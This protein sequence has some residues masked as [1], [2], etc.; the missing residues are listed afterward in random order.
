MQLLLREAEEREVS[1]LRVLRQEDRA[2]QSGGALPLH[3]PF[4]AYF[5]HLRAYFEQQPRLTAALRGVLR[6][7]R[8]GFEDAC[9]LYSKGLVIEDTPGRYR[10]RCTLYERYLRALWQLPAPP[11]A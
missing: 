7:E 4:A 3:S 6:G 11:P 9:R 5:A 8:P 2:L 10:I 1:L